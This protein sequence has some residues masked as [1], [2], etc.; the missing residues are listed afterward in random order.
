MDRAIAEGHI[1]YCQAAGIPEL[2]HALAED[3][4]VQA[5]HSLYTLNF[6]LVGSE[7]NKFFLFVLVLMHRSDI[8]EMYSTVQRTSPFKAEAN[9]S[10][11]NF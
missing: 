11:E 3:V 4:R 6:V 1:G 10:L 2:R 8:V 9:Q 5:I 7:N